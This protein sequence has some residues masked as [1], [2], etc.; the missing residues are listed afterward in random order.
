LCISTAIASWSTLKDQI[1]VLE[2]W[3]K[4]VKTFMLAEQAMAVGEPDTLKAQL[5]QFSVMMTFFY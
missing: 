5:E 3:F 4:D 2:N 1:N